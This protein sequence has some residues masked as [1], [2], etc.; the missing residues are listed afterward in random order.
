MEY[1]QRLCLPYIYG[2]PILTHPKQMRDFTSCLVLNP[3]YQKHLR[4][5]RF[6]GAFHQWNVGETCGA[7]HELVELATGI[8]ELRAIPQKT[9][10][11]ILLDFA[12]LTLFV[13]GFYSPGEQLW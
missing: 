13:A 8:N 1:T 5:I 10:A 11:D 9:L 2:Y 6:W 12:L 7:I 3:S 4:S